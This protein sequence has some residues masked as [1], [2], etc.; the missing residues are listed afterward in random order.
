MQYYKYCSG[1]DVALLDVEEVALQD[2]CQ[3]KQ[4]VCPEVKVHIIKFDTFMNFN[5]KVPNVNTELMMNLEM[6]TV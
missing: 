1:D 2:P 3:N 6:N 5:I 4:I